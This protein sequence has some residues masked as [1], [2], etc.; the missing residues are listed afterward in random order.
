LQQLWKKV[1][2]EIA[3]NNPSVS[4]GGTKAGSQKAASSNACMKTQ[5]EH[6]QHL[7]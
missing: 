6:F 1:S 5:D 3:V 2:L 4:R 7:L